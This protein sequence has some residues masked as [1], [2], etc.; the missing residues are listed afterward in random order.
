M[1]DGQKSTQNATRT[2]TYR[3]LRLLSSTRG[4]R[5][6]AAL[7][8]ELGPV[9]VVRPG[10]LADHERARP[11]LRRLAE[12]HGRIEHPRVPPV[13]CAALDGDDM[14]VALRSPAVANGFEVAARL[15]QSERRLPYAAADGFVLS[16]REALD[17][18]HRA[19]GGPHCLGRISL[20]NLLFDELGQVQLVGFGHNVAVDDEWGRPDPR[21]R[22]FQAHELLVGADATPMT[23]YVALLQLSRSI[24]GHVDLPPTIQRVI[25][26]RTDGTLDRLVA[27]WMRFTEQR[28]IAELPSK[29]PPLEEALRVASRLRSLLGVRPDREG[30]ARIARPLL[31]AEHVPPARP[32]QWVVAADAS[33]VERDGARVRLSGPG[34]AIFV[35]LLDRLLWE[36]EP[37]LDVWALFDH[38]WPGAPTTY[39]RAMNRV[40]AAVSRLRRAGLGELIE[41]SS[42]GYRLGAGSDIVRLAGTDR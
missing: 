24:V 2:P 4:F 33:W 23:D 25:E 15:S 38:A 13:A 27:R 31:C 1:G 19:P 28:V 39:E 26:G 37:D 29:R 35:A 10:R 11:R 41:H 16:L 9:V 12:S 21:V 5:L 18:A 32:G 34:R 3:D 36:G 7:H 6:F 17:A 30:L 14:H 42:Q 22:A 40:H 20:A 8:A